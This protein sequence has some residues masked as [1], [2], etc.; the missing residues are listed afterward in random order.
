LGGEGE[1]GLLENARV[2]RSALGEPALEASRAHPGGVGGHLDPR[3]TGFEK[4]PEEQASATKQVLRRGRRRA[5]LPPG[6]GG[7]VGGWRRPA[8]PPAEERAR[9]CN[10]GESAARAYLRAAESFELSEIGLTDA[11]ELDLGW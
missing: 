5:M 1:A 10:T 9:E 11:L 3:L 2:A 4:R 6:A 7:A 8:D